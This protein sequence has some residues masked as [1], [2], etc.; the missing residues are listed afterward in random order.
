MI[1]LTEAVLAWVIHPDDVATVA[2][3]SVGAIA[4][5][6]VG[7]W[8]LWADSIV[9]RCVSGWIAYRAAG[10]PTEPRRELNSDL[11]LEGTALSASTP[12]RLA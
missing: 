12:S 4:S 11:P 8:G 1:E 7:P 2:S 9:A 6:R 3:M 10:Y 5:A